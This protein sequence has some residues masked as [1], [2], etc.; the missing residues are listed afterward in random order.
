ML[1]N[2]GITNGNLL[3]CRTEIDD[4]TAAI[5]ECQI[6][7]LC[8]RVSCVESDVYDINQCPGLSCT[9][10][11]TEEDLEPVYCC[12][13]EI[14]QC[15]GC[16]VQECLDCLQCEIDDINTCP[17][18]TCVG[19]VTG[20]CVNDVLYNPTTGIVT[21]PDYPDVS[22]EIADL[23]E[24]VCCVEE[25]VTD[26]YTCPGLSCT[27]TL[28]DSDLD[29]LRNSITCLESCPGLDCIGDVTTSTL[30]CCVTDINTCIDGVKC[31]VECLENCPG[32]D[33]TGSVNTVT[34]NGCAFT[35]TS[36]KTLDLKPSLTLTDNNRKLTA[37]LGNQTSD[38][39]CLPEGINC[40]GTMKNI[41]CTG[42][43]CNWDILF[44]LNANTAQYSCDCPF[45]Y[46]PDTGNL[47][48]CKVSAD[49]LS[50]NCDVSIGGDLTVAG[51]ITCVHAQEIDTSCENIKLRY[52]ATTAL[53][54]G[55]YSGVCVT[56][57]NG[58][59]DFEIGVDCDGTLK[60]GTCPD[61]MEAVATRDCSGNMENEY[62][63]NWNC[64]SKMLTTDGVTKV[65]CLCSDGEVT[66]TCFCGNL[67]G[68]ANNSTCF[69]GCTYAEA[70]A[71][72]RSGLIGDACFDV[73]C[74]TT[75]KCRVSNGGSLCLGKLA[76]CNCS[77]PTV[78]N[79][80]ISFTTNG[81]TIDSFTLNQNTDK[82][83]HL[84]TFV[85]GVCV[86]CGT[87]CK[88]K[89]KDDCALCLSAN[90]F[91]TN[92]TIS[93]TT[94]PGACC[95]GT[96]VPSDL[97][98]ICNN[99]SCLQSC[100][101]LNCTGTVVQSDIADFITMNDV[102][103]CGYTTCIGTVT[104]VNGCSGSVLTDVPGAG[105]CVYTKYCQGSF[106]TNAD[107]PLLLS[108]CDCNTSVCNATWGVSAC[109]RILYN[110]TTGVL[111]TTSLDLSGTL[112]DMYCCTLPSPNNTVK[113]AR[114][115]FLDNVSYSTTMSPRLQITV[116]S[117][118]YDVNLPDNRITMLNGSLYGICGISRVAGSSTTGDVVWVKYKGYRQ[119]HFCSNCRFCIDVCTTDPGCT[120]SAPAYICIGNATTICR[121][122]TS[123]NQTYFIPMLGACNSSAGAC[124][125]VDS[126]GALSYNPST[127]LLCGKCIYLADS[128]TNCAAKI[129]LRGSTN[130]CIK[131][132]G[133]NAK[134]QFENCDGSQNVCLIFT[135]CDTYKTGA[136]LTL[137]GNQSQTHFVTPFLDT[138]G[139]IC[140][141]GVIRACNK[142]GIVVTNNM[143]F[144]CCFCKTD[145]NGYPTFR[146]VADVTNWWDYCGTTCSA[147]AMGMLGD[148]YVQR[149][150]DYM[151]CEI[152][153][154]AAYA[155]YRR[156]EASPTG[157]SKPM[158]LGLHYQVHFGSMQA[159]PMMVCDTVNNKKYIALKLTGSGKAYTF[160]GFINGTDLL[161]C[162]EYC[163]T[164][165][166]ALPSGWT[167]I[168]SGCITPASTM[169]VTDAVCWNGCTY[170]SVI[171]SATWAITSDTIGYTE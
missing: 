11:L 56:K 79:K 62:A 25:D 129:T 35:G 117:A 88:C 106:S 66:A 9:G 28:V 80:T 37:T 36:D 65:H 17:G 70:C 91:N 119:I 67:S 78:N 130:A 124:I 82:T 33:C 116:Y 83:I 168:I 112:T 158:D 162:S 109:C 122:A 63:V 3:Q 121:V 40:T 75:C 34:L 51:T 115:C 151:N 47:T 145:N 10:T 147:C 160:N 8:G 135:D 111:C 93:T 52:D 104:S 156:E 54:S 24:R 159:C 155:N 81:S 127:N 39:L 165:A 14:S 114:V 7:G 49:C 167:E 2:L 164:S 100:P 72:I 134:I 18:L 97:T 142:S 161:Q 150:S 84:D 138:T 21:L 154:I 170:A 139:E 1:Q 58:T 12:I 113:Y 149:T 163:Y 43:N 94:Y 29:P 61:N 153:K 120:Y 27:G 131:C 55:H 77:I 5:L 95:T 23:T 15:I 53:P 107:R 26:I 98:T 13:D 126:D 90:A 99:I 32:L 76:F 87:T 157:I 101:G 110:P 141:F 73:Y 92:A 19:T 59:D 132:D 71:D 30:N 146:L 64:N 16:N 6:N 42:I 89:I 123:N 46:N 140:S 169:C 137:T 57:Y 86:F 45:K 48:V 118:L 171:K 133:S 22:G 20:V 44:K 69:N 103:A 60:I 125:W 74:C 128:T 102:D 41:Q 148:I 152:G 136:S 96:L 144:G 108:T 38:V 31:R 4:D 105:T 68:T 50:A 143:K 85:T 166:S